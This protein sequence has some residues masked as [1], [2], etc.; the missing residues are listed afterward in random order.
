VLSSSTSYKQKLSKQ[1]QWLTFAML[2][3]CPNLGPLAITRIWRA[4]VAIGARAGRNACRLPMAALKD[5]A[6]GTVWLN[7]AAAI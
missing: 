2:F 6:A 5:T 1:K 3:F 7:I 4:G